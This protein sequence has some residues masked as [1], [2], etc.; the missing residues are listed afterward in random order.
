MARNPSV[1]LTPHQEAFVGSLVA[2][3]RYHGVSE[4]VRAG[5]RLLEEK[6]SQRQAV[7]GRIEAAV[8]EG[9][10]SGPPTELEDIE[11]IIAK[12]EA[13]IAAERG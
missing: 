10:A 11:T 12:A 13:E 9:L 2:S 8:A 3:G 7:L 4:V 1:S 5:L 6:E